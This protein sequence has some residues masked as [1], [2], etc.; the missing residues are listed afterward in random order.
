MEQ[1]RAGN[2]I[3]LRQEAGRYRSLHRRAVKRIEEQRQ[4]YDEKIERLTADYER[5]LAASTATIVELKKQ[6][7]TLQDLHFGKPGEATVSVAGDLTRGGKKPKR[8]RG[9]QPGR[10]GHGRRPHDELP[11]VE[12]V[13]KLSEQEACCPVCGLPAEETTR[14]N[15]SE[16]VDYEVRIVRK[17]RRRVHYRRTCQC[18]GPPRLI[19]A[20]L[21]PRA[22]PQSKYSDAFWIEV[23][24]FKYE[25]QFPLERQVRHLDGH[26]LHDVAPGTLCGGIERCGGLLQPLYDEMV[27]YDK[28]QLLRLMDETTMKVFIEV[29]GRS[30]RLW[31]LWQSSTPETCI[32]FLDPTRSFDVPAKYLEDTPKDSVVCA[33]RYVVYKKLRQAIAFCWAHVRR[34]F[35]RI[36]RSQR[37]NLGWALRW[38]NRIKRLYR[39]NRKRVEA[40]DDPKP[41]AAAQRE[42]SA[43]L[44]QICSECDRELASTNWWLDDSRRKTLESL[45][46]HWA[47][48]T[49][50]LTDPDIPLDTNMAE[51]LFRP[52]ANFR[53]NCFGVHSKNFGNLTAVMLSIFA[54]LRLNG[55]SPRLFLAEYFAAVAQAGGEAKR[56]AGNFLPW[57]LPEERRKRLV[58]APEW[59]NTS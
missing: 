9:Q 54:T 55:V 46:N 45:K 40:R 31:W 14:Q 49:L 11:C 38:L 12:D 57:D 34:D 53:K 32:F 56:V 41:F 19:S 52:V 7:K 43:V 58:R 3:G 16:E 8:K 51:R 20:P 5:K 24:L 27:R 10:E 17:R 26:G 48:L 2:I 33:D 15:E 23:L 37:R 39:S 28:S 1:S 13:L 4:Y 22:L 30:G 29:E 18:E 35:V 21:P 6:V 44:E 47:G 59:P 36:G 50:F 25:Y 42:V